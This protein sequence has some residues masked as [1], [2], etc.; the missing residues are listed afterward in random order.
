MQDALSFQLTFSVILATAASEE[1]NGSCSQ[2]HARQAV[3][4][5]CRSAGML[6]L[7][8]PPV[9]ETTQPPLKSTAFAD[10]SA[11]RGSAPICSAGK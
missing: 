7:R 10:K 9:V 5:L 3:P 11:S 2:S 8:S 6:L 1:S 4:P